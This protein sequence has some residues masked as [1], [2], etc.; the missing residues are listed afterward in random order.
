[1][2]RQNRRIKGIKIKEKYF[3]LSQFADDT[4]V[5]LGGSEECLTE[6]IETLKAFTLIL[7]I[8]GLQMKSEKIQLVWIGSKTKLWN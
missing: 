2:L 3:L 1:M 5:R 4:T 8:A 6:C 7:M